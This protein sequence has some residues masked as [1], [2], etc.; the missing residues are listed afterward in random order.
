MYHARKAALVI[1]VLAAVAA[2]VGSGYLLGYRVGRTV[3]LTVEVRN[4]AGT[5][6]AVPSVDFGTF[7]QAWKTVDER[8]LK[9]PE[10]VSQ[11]RVYGAI[12]GL[13]GS[14]QDPY[15]L[16]LDPEENK[17]F[18]EDIQGNF[19]GIGA[20]IGSRKG[21]I[22][23]IAPLKGSPAERAG[24][25]PADKILTVNGTSTADMSVEEAVRLIRGPE[26]T[27]VV[28]L[29]F[30]E[31]WEKPKEFKIIREQIEIP[32]VE[33]E[34]KD[35][36]IAY[37]SIQS[38]NA[39][40]HRLFYD[41]MFKAFTKGTR[42]LVLDLRN[43]PGGYLQIAVDIAGWFLP[44]GTLVASEEGRV[45]QKQEFRANGNAALK[46]IPVVVLVNEGSASASEIL[47]GA[48][49][50]VRGV[51]LVGAKTF[52]KGTVQQLEGLRDGSAVKLTVAHWVLP[53]GKVLENEGLVPDIE[54]TRTDEEIEAKRD[55][56]LLKA[57]D[58]L[59]EEIRKRPTIFKLSAQ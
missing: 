41:A 12:R 18:E 19:S 42:G 26:K 16:F 38:F 46:D 31:G 2:L 59:K 13:V 55:P 34:M 43:N 22:V 53:S 5:E 11:E 24:L 51:K 29:I 33:L 40:T 25:K 32:T 10:V 3:P 52:G 7:W 27:E 14:L 30:R 44:R 6:E 39:N 23:V 15:S 8:Y 56:Q 35:D 4:I 58:I 54:V 45:I 21:V 50:D 36:N 37:V 17:K 20:E 9:A 47:A 48:L 1:L 49:R 57:I 28:L